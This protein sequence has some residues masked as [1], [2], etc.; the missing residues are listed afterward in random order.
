MRIYCWKNS[1][2]F[3]YRSIISFYK[4]TAFLLTCRQSV[5]H[6]DLKPNNLL[7]SREGVLKISDFGFARMQIQSAYEGYTP[8]NFTMPYESPEQM[9]GMLNY[10]DKVDMWAAGCIMSELY[11]GKILFPVSKATPY[12]HIK[13][14]L[15][16]FEWHFNT[17]NWHWTGLWLWLESQNDHATMWLYFS[18]IV[19][20]YWI[21]REFC[22]VTTSPE[23]FYRR[24]TCRRTDHRSS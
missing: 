21:Y 9:L 3:T 4:G 16:L 12:G 19:S 7:I 23:S 2:Y 14:Q 22:C 8:M 15:N 1:S 10:T 6:R 5:I 18:F 20:S 11:T 17:F 13:T 24:F